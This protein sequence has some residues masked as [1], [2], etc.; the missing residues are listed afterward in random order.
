M[1]TLTLFTLTLLQGFIFKQDR[2]APARNI[3]K[4]FF[5]GKVVNIYIFLFKVP[6]YSISGP[7][8][9]K[10]EHKLRRHKQSFEKIATTVVLDKDENLL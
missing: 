1:I 4:S 6:R 8:P 2:E 7:I 3:Q 9:H 10:F 5:H